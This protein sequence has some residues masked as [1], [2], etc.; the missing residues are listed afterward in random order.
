[1][2]TLN[3]FPMITQEE[4]T[5]ALEACTR[6]ILNNMPQFG[7]NFQ[8]PSCENMFYTTMENVGWTNGFWTGE[9]WLAYEFCKD[10]NLKE[11]AMWQCERF[12]ERIKNRVSIEHHDMGFLYT[13]SC[14]AAYKLT[15]DAQAKEAAIL[16]ADNLLSRF[17][18]KGNFIQSCGLPHELPYY[19]MIVD[20]L[21]NIP[22]LYWATEVTGDERYRDAA[23]RHFMTTYRLAL[24][25]DGSSVQVM[26][27]DVETGA[28]VRNRTNQ[29]YSN[30]S[31]WSRGQA[32]AIY[33]PALAY[34]YT[35]MPECIEM[36]RKATDYFVENLPEDGVPYFDLI[37]KE[38][39]EWPRDSS[40]A[41]I[42]ICG[43]LEM[44]KYLEEEEAQHYRTYAMKLA[45]V[46][47]DQ[48]LVRDHKISNGLLLH[49]TYCQV[50]DYNTQSKCRGVDQCSSFGDYFFME[51]LT[52]LFKDWKIYW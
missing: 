8:S 31:T 23:T 20:C 48:C 9:I 21:M 2:S 35:R 43:M 52:R 33:G 24:R 3:K 10:E 12:Y 6:Q 41:A 4:V 45:K 14:V 18:D 28:F 49:G 50:T 39:D 16:A 34:R 30:D 27:F 17:R 44:A 37:F 5:D 7:Y 15:G 29:G 42:A 19:R 40:A 51:A 11:A 25:E 47:Y 38:G 26:H 46:L 36:F 22:L 13:P 32:W 1:M